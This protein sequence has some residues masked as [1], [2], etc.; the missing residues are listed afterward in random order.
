M[1]SSQEQHSRVSIDDN[2]IFFEAVEGK[3][4]TRNVYGLGQLGDHFVASLSRQ[5][6]DADVTD[7]PPELVDQMWETIT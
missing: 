3:N 2:A 4:K 6:I 5:P 1:F 7:V